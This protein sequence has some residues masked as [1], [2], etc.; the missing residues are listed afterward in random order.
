ML[1]TI[2]LKLAFSLVLIVLG[3]AS[4]P[5]FITNS[6]AT[7]P[8]VSG[9]LIDFG[10]W[11]V[12]WTEMDMQDHF[13]PY[14]ALSTACNENNFT[15]TLE[16]GKVK[17]INGLLAGDTYTWD[18]WTISK[19]SIT[20]VKQSDP[21][22]TNLSDYTISAWAYTSSNEIPTV[23]VDSSGRSIYGYP[24]A[25]RTV[26]LSPALTEIMGSLNAISTIVGTDMYS[27]YPESVVIGRNQGTIKILGDFLNPSF[28][29][30]VAQKPDMVFCDGSL[31]THNIATD[32]LRK[33]GINTVLMYG[34][35]NVQEIMDNIYIAGEAIG[36]DQRA[37]EV[38]R[39]IESAKAEIID[40]LAAVQTGK[41]K[42]TLALS[43]DKSP[44]VSGSNTYVSDLAYIVN[45][46]N[47]FSS[48]SGWAQINSEQIIA[49]NPS[50]III[51]NTDYMSNQSDYDSMI[52]SL[53]SEW[54]TT[55]AYKN[56]RIYLVS[57]AAGNMSTLP[58]PRFI[59]IME[60]TA[61]ILNPDAFTDIQVP[62]YVGD[63]YGDFL[64]F[65]K[66]LDFNN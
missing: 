26:T 65:T 47:V 1:N 34:G 48:L 61:R 29:Q 17:E 32:K 31:Y 28:E 37:A 51:L 50:V 58:G 41:V 22:N 25:Q 21:S 64:T 55:N 11:N 2:K 40:T 8:Q 56:G 9:F 18:L 19:N 30:I 66:D 24:Q 57:G 16:E 15:H 45:G 13:D 3:A 60:L 39:L 49:A 44:W 63:N 5:I 38:I 4:V 14:D 7:Q 59:Q 12:A 20:W 36:Y 54:K 46:N 53:P 62:K 35:Q 27:N 23:A 10:D 42:V 33:I 52:N 6:N 43:P